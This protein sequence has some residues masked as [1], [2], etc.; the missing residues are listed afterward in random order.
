[1]VKVQQP[2]KNPLPHLTI[3][4][5]IG[6]LISHSHDLQQTIKSIVTIVAERME[7]EVCSLYIL[8][9]QKTRLTLRA[10][11]GLDQESVGRVSMG[12]DEG[13]AGLVVE[14]MGTVM[15]VDA[16]THSRYKYFPEILD[17]EGQTTFCPSCGRALIRRSWHDILEYQLIENHCPCGRKISGHFLMGKSANLRPQGRSSLQVQ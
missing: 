16:L 11:M 2:I 13:L 7:T 9:R 12:V 4:E 14:K 10:S 15:V 5:D 1:M 17:D 8:D 6:A 3:L